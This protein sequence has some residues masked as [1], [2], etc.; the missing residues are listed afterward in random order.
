MTALSLGPCQPSI[1]ALLFPKR[2]TVT[3]GKGRG[4]C[5][6][7]QHSR[8][9]RAACEM[10]AGVRRRRDNVAA[11]A[12]CGSSTVVH[13]TWG[14]VGGTQHRGAARGPA[15]RSRSAARRPRVLGRA[16]GVGRGGGAVQVCHHRGAVPRD[17]G[18]LG[19]GRAAAGVCVVRG[20]CEAGARCTMGGGLVGD[21]CVCGPPS[22]FWGR[23]RAPVWGCARAR[24]GPRS[25]RAAAR[26]GRR[27]GRA[28]AAGGEGR[29]ARGGAAE[30]AADEVLV[31]VAVGRAQRAHCAGGGAGR[32]GRGEAHCTRGGGRGAQRA[33][34]AAETGGAGRRAAPAAPPAAARSASDAGD[35]PKYC[36]GGRRA[37]GGG[38][39]GGGAPLA[40]APEAGRATMR[41][42][43]G[44]A[45]RATRPHGRAARPRPRPRPR[46]RGGGLPTFAIM[47]SSVAA[48]IVAGRAGRGVAGCQQRA[49]RGSRGQE[50]AQ[51]RLEE[52][53]NNIWCPTPGGAGGKGGGGASPAAAGREAA[54]RAQGSHGRCAPPPSGWRQ[55]CAAAG[56][57]TSGWARRRG[58]GRRAPRTTAPVPFVR[59]RPDCLRAHVPGSA[60]A[61]GL[62]THPPRAGS[63][64]ARRSHPQRRRTRAAVP[65]RQAR[66]A[67]AAVPT[68]ARREL[69]PGCGR[70]GP[71]RQAARAGKWSIHNCGLSSLAVR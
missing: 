54:S 55:G 45:S 20:G 1:T 7:A 21:S 24:D 31:G 71:R 70:G 13:G 53:R 22:S 65:V 49:P 56:A 35:V 10:G 34:G 37:A 57:A 39:A 61:A 11:R 36:A 17:R 5:C 50:R 12:Q 26:A 3:Q 58:P 51:E 69:S 29:P 38:R 19:G 46:A 44:S 59:R 66:R 28:A 64:T 6:G 43:R 47:T 42:A 4:R 52:L 9:A 68:R 67:T 16:F 62:I 18:G 15:L 48:G 33:G 27:R 30:E 63:P 14:S 8:H 2:L 23:V 60:A 40:A 41:A 32:A 25:A